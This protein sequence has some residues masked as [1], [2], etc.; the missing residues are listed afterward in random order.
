MK[1]MYFLIILFFLAFKGNTQA[2]PNNPPAVIKDYYHLETKAEQAERL[3]WFTAAKYGMFIHFGLS[4]QLGGRWKGNQIKGYSEWIQAFASIKGKTYSELIKTFN[5]EK[6]NA[7]E[8]VKAAKESGMT[9]LVITSKHHEG[10]CL[11]DSKYTDFDIGN[12]PYQKDII[13]QLKEACDKYDLRF[14]IYYSVLDWHHGSQVSLTSPCRDWFS[15]YSHYRPRMKVSQKA[16]YIEYMNN[17]L[18]ELVANYN[19]D[20]LWFDGA[21]QFWWKHKDAVN[22]YNY[23]RNLKPSIIINNRYGNS[24]GKYDKDFKTPEQRS[25]EN[26]GLPWEACYTLNSSWGYKIDD[27]NY[28]EADVVWQKLKD[29]NVRGGNLLLNIGP[30]GDGSVPS[31]SIERLKEIKV[32]I[33]GQKEVIKLKE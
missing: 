26:S 21:W 20:I 30:K 4:S 9:Y 11:W 7:E 22:L 16:A 32:L 28:K 18:A 25:N 10:F 5:P 14:G 17:Q 24:A 27:E 1:K 19:P 12:T 23:V 8:I 13:K 6:F 31:K 29:I 33:D 15:I 2:P 3:T